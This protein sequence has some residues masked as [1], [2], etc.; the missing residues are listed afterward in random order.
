M[1]D[2]VD[3]ATERAEIARQSAIAQHNRRQWRALLRPDN[4]N[5]ANCGDEIPALR[6]RAV[7]GARLC[8][9]CQNL[10][11]RQRRVGL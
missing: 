1:T 3:L 2:T 8:V 4:P 6:R 9:D 10:A 7:P 5:C 11:E